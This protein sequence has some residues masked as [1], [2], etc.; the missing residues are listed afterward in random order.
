MA[1]LGM[2][3]PGNHKAKIMSTKIIII[4]FILVSSV[5]AC[6]K[7]N[8]PGDVIYIKTTPDA[9]QNGCT[10]KENK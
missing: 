10:L 4:F 7:D 3:R 8:D 9:C 5:L 2:V 6:V 1:G